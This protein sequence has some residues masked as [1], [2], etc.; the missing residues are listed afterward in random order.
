MLFRKNKSKDT[1]ERITQLETD[2]RRLEE[3]WT[4]VYSKFRT[5]QMRVAKQAQRLEQAPERE[6]T[7]PEG[8]SPGGLPTTLSPRAQLIQKQILE[9][10]RANGGT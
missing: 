7:Q 4:D 3:E 10:R 9:R 6:G 1:D 8:E 5:L 2:M